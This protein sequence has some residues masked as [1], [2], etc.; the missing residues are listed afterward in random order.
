[1]QVEVQDLPSDSPGRNFRL[2]GLRFGVA[3]ARPKAYL[4]A[5]LHADEMPG[6]LVLH[7]LRGLLEQA[8]AQGKVLGEVILVPLANPI[9]FGQWVQSKP[10]GRQDLGTMQNFNRD[11]PD[12][13]ALCGDALQGQLGPDPVRNLALIRAEFGKA[14][15]EMLVPDEGTALRRALMLWSHD[16]DHVLDLHCDHH[17]VLHLYTSPAHP[18]QGRALA[19]AVGAQLVLLAQVSG[20]NAF[21]EAHSAPFHLLAERFG[22]DHPIPQA[23]FATTLEYRGQFDVAD[24]MA[25][26]DAANLMVYLAA[27]GLISGPSAPAHA[28]PPE[29]PLSGAVEAAAPIGGIVTWTTKA[30]EAVEEG[31]ILGHVTDPTSGQR[32][33]INA[34]VTGILFRQELWRSCLRGQELAHVAGP[35]PKRDGNLLSD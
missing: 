22:P 28:M 12:L 27:M 18:D 30:G 24:D 7:H 19:Q 3:G 14:L 17:S 13:A 31:Q 34:P 23:C 29:Y 11:W 26:A 4:Q 35:I 21:D 8:E 9:G 10:Q 25:A 32:A 33:T 1:M 6:P 20:G 15:R 2:T 16:A 5:G